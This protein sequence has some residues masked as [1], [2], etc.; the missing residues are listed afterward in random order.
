MSY[1]T[2]TILAW[3]LFLYYY[4]ILLLLYHIII[5]GR[6]SCPYA[7]PY[8]CSKFAVEAFSDSLR[9]E[10]QPWKVGVHL[11]EPTFYKT[12]IVNKE[13]VSNAWMKIW[14]DQAQHVKDEISEEQ[15][16]NCK[17]INTYTRCV[18]EKY[19]FNFMI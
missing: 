15:V 6:L 1:T 12:E 17:Y 3:T 16:Q 18:G 19:P 11:I 8:F 10:L 13:N 4:I 2:F 14:N 9:I 7:A 5:L